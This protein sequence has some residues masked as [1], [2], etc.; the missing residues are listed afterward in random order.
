MDVTGVLTLDTEGRFN[1][2]D[3]DALQDLSVV[4]PYNEEALDRWDFNA[5]EEIDSSDVAFMQN[6]VDQNVDSKIFGDV[7]NLDGVPDCE[8][9]DQIEPMFGYELGSPEYKVA[10]DYDLDGDTDDDDRIQFMDQVCM[11]YCEGDTNGDGLINAADL[12]DLL[13]SFGTAPAHPAYNYKADFN[14]DG[15]I[16]VEDLSAMLTNFGS[17]C[18]P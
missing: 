4:D 5:N 6:L 8:I 7:L 17:I 10:L 9:K 2:A 15:R 13:T 14:Q 12:S 18:T 11:Y 1:Q 3:V 16:D